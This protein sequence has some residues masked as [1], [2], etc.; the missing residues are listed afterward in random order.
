[1]RRALTA[2]V[3]SLAAPATAHACAVCG[4]A[5]ER[6][7]A[8]F[9]GTTIGLSLLPL[10]LIGGGLWWISRHA[11]ERMAGEFADRELPAGAP[12]KATGGGEG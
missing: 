2:V 5:V 11:R 8:A 12:T 3:L 7:K 6:S 9:V 1:M 10:A 4:A